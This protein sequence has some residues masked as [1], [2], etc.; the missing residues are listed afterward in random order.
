[1]RT[2]ERVIKV[3]QNFTRSDRLLTSSPQYVMVTCL[4]HRDG[5]GGRGGWALDKGGWGGGGGR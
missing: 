1:M 5:V 2:A 3:G 4:T